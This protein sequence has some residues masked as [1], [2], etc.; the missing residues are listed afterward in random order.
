VINITEAQKISR[1][2]KSCWDCRHFKE[3][4][5]ECEL[6]W[7]GAGAKP[8]YMPCHGKNYSPP[9]KPLAYRRP[10]GHLK[11]Q[12][13]LK[14]PIIAITRD[15][16][17]AFAYTPQIDIFIQ[18]HPDKVYPQSPPKNVYCKDYFLPEEFGDKIYYVESDK[19]SKEYI[20]VHIRPKRL[21]CQLI[22]PA[23]ETSQYI[24]HA[25]NERLKKDDN[26]VK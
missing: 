3:D 23:L 20:R 22:A 16:I 13:F 5:E 17:A 25:L 24:Q 4:S 6:D 2:L 15:H 1:E 11:N 19:F 9:Y 7:V 26:V 8:F 14:S 18:A 12:Q 10:K 21:L